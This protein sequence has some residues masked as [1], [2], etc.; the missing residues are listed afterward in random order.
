[1]NACSA[2]SHSKVISENP[3]WL[4]WG[5]TRIFLGNIGPWAGSMPHSPAGLWEL[6]T[7]VW[8]LVNQYPSSTRVVLEYNVFSIFMFI[9]LGKTSTRVVLAPAPLTRV[10][11]WN[12]FPQYGHGTLKPAEYCWWGSVETSGDKRVI[13]ISTPG[14][15]SLAPGKFEWNYQYVIFKWILAIDGWGISCEIALIWMPLD[16]TDDQSTL[17]QVM[18]WCHQ[19][20]NHYLSQCWPRFLSPYGITGPQWVKV[21]GRNTFFI[22]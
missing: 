13:T 3:C 5:L 14:L 16:F 18:A 19:A 20:T 15:D 22:H 21:Q 10:A 11:G 9:I 1:M 2:A 12:F 7:R 17:V 6:N 8:V 4:T